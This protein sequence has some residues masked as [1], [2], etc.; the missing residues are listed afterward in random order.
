M[1]KLNNL[2]YF[3]L[4]PF[5]LVC[6]FIFN[7]NSKALAAGKDATIEI[8]QS[9]SI[10][11][12]CYIDGNDTGII[13]TDV[14]GGGALFWRNYSTKV[15]CQKEGVVTLKCYSGIFSKDK[16]TTITCAKKETIPSTP[17]EPSDP[18]CEALLTE[19]IIN[20]LQDIFDL[21]KFVDVVLVV[22]LTIITF[23][24]AVAKGGDEL[25][26]AVN[27][28]IKRVI[29]GVIIF[30]IPTLIDFVFNAIG[31]YDTCGIG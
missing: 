13:S 10:D 16:Y 11:E 23:T 22:A 24:Q 20:L 7:I 8:G 29:I 25:K 1:K 18:N 21:I 6:L 3:F 4:I 19:D 9:R 27:I 28:T 2:H 30:F 31:L 17:I 5:T 14:S 12:E 15:T 26:K